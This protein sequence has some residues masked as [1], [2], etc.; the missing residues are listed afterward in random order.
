MVKILFNQS[1]IFPSLNLTF[2]ENFLM[3]SSKESRFLL[4]ENVIG[5]KIYRKKKT[6]THFSCPCFSF[7]F[8]GEQTL[9]GLLQSFEVTINVFYKYITVNFLQ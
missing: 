4:P 1:Q 8:Y 3:V 5:S 9:Y 7:Y 6:L 2:S